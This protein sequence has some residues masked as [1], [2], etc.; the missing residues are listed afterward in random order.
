MQGVL[1]DRISVS[2]VKKYNVQPFT[3]SAVLS[4]KRIVYIGINLIIF[5]LKLYFLSTPLGTSIYIRVSK[6]P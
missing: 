5:P 4:P 1:R 2:H 3:L 6:L